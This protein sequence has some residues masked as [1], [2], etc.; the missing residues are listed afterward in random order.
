MPFREHWRALRLDSFYR[1]LGGESECVVVR[2]Y[3]FRGFLRGSAGHGTQQCSRYPRRNRSPPVK[4]P[5]ARQRTDRRAWVKRYETPRET[6][7][8]SPMPHQTIFITGASSGIGRALALEL[9]KKGAHV[10]IAARRREVLEELAREIRSNGGGAATVVPVDVSDPQAAKEAVLQ[11]ERDLGA[12]DMVI[13]NA[14]TS[15]RELAATLSWDEVS[16]VLDVNLRGALATIVAAIPIF[17]AQQRGHVVGVSSLAGFFGV[18][19]HAAYSSSKAALTTFLASIRIDLAPIGIRVT[20]VQPG[21]VETPMTAA[22]PS[23]T[24]FL[25]TAEKA[26][27]VIVRRL[28]RAPRSIA[29]SWPL[30][31]ATRLA[32]LLP[33]IVVEPIL[34]AVTSDQRAPAHHPEL[35][36]ERIRHYSF[37]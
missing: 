14:G 6:R 7:Y 5:S 4:G 2:N 22:M 15:S 25:W 3:T 8:T 36:Q 11:V 31:L 33:A 17:V 23:P 37:K 10:A 1:F 21:F 29:F 9:A 27:R 13:A 12:L 16:R 26:A 32:P 24:P 30:A 20:D 18:P 28:E 19:K 34:R 35:A